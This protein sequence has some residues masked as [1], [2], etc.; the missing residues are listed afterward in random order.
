MKRIWKSILCLT[1]ILGMLLPLY[2]EQ[3]DAYTRDQVANYI[4]KTGYK[5]YGAK[6]MFGAPMEYAPYRFDCS[7]FTKYVYGKAGIYLPRTSSQQYKVGK[8]VSPS[9]V[10][11]GDLLFFKVSGRSGI[12][13]VGIYIGNYRML[14]TYGDGGVKVSYINSYWKSRYVGAKRVF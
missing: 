7:S 12:G 14:N 4:I 8:Y 13:H 11:K 3:A 9:Q 5:Y 1:L 10:R 2:P 6:Y